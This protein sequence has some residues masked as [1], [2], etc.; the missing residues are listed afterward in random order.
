MNTPRQALTDADFTLTK[1]FHQSRRHVVYNTG[2]EGIKSIKN[3]KLPIGS[4]REKKITSTFTGPFTLTDIVAN[5]LACTLKLPPHMGLHPTL[6]VGLLKP[7]LHD[8][9]FNHD[10]P[11]PQPASS[12]TATKN[13]K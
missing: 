7:Y 9:R 4:S 5:G 2:D 1:R 8:S 12:R 11:S 3:M 10:A 6:H 13:K